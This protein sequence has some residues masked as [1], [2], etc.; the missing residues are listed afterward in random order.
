MNQWSG[1]RRI[2]PDGNCFYRAYL[3]GIFENLLR[4]PEI[5]ITRFK[6]AVEDLSNLC[7]ASGYD[8]FAID[9]FSDMIVDQLDILR[10]NPSTVTLEQKIFDDASVDGYL[11]A[12]MR[13]CCGAYLRAHASEF[14]PILPSGFG[15]VDEFVKTE[16]DPMFKD[17]EYLQVVALSRAL[18]V[19]LSIVYLDQSDGPPVTHSFGDASLAEKVTLLYKPGHYDLLYAF[20]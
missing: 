6:G 10:D 9:D 4:S 1:A 18:N 11:V 15:S 3:Y 5:L 17:C 12:F 2:R 7:K 19:P 14:E 8:S 20:S 13:C 16:V